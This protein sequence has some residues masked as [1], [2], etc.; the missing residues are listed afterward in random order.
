[1]H[2]VMHQADDFDMVSL[3]LERR[4]LLLGLLASQN[5]LDNLGLFNKESTDDS[6]MT[7]QY[8]KEKPSC[9]LHTLFGRSWRI[10]YHRKH[11]EPS[12]WSC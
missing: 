9:T 6:T 8:T 2:D 12:S 4:P 7:N 11:V 3:F 1:M 5:S 10:G